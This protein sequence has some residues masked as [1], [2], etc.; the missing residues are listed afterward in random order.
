MDLDLEI[1]SS[2]FVY[3]LGTKVWLSEHALTRR[4]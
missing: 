4:C 2:T 1:I 3:D